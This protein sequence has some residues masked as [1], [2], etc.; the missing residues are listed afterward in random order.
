[1][2]V[3]GESESHEEELVE[4]PVDEHAC[5]YAEGKLDESVEGEAESL[6]EELAKGGSSLRRLLKGR[7]QRG[8]SAGCTRESATLADG[9]ACATEA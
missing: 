6:V 3:E 5:G 8:G 1:M 7:P 4:G 2:R 9:G